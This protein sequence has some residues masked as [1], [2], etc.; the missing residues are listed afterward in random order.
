MRDDTIDLVSANKD[1]S[2]SIQDDVKQYQEQ[3]KQW[4]QNTVAVN[5]Y[6]DALNEKLKTD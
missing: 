6:R 1:L 5:Q 4:S 3:L 2:A